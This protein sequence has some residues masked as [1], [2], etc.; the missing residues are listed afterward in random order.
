[1]IDERFNGNRD[2]QAIYNATGIA[3]A[4]ITQ[5]L[6]MEDFIRHAHY[7]PYV[8]NRL[9]DDRLR[10]VWRGILQVKVWL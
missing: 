5:G 8:D 3:L 9:T 4:H 2:A 1:M 7:D 10:E 6:G